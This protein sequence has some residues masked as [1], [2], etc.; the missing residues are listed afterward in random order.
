[1][2]KHF[3]GR[4]SQGPGAYLNIDQVN[5]VSTKASQYSVPKDHRGLLEKKG[6]INPGP[7]AYDHGAAFKTIK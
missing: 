5:T 3:Y 6:Q 2:D 7:G 4:E 1:M